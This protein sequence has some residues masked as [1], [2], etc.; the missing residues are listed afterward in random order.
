M[1]CKIRQS[2]NI[3]GIELPLD[4]YELN[5][6][7]ITQFADDTTIFVKDE[8]SIENVINVLD[9]FAEISGL[10]L[11]KSKTDAVWIGSR[12]SC[13]IRKGNINWKFEPDN[14]VKILGVTLSP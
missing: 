1:S 4:D 2:D 12:K 7:K 5:V 14:S 11:N 3:R 8:E 6:V 13:K 10:H 9:N